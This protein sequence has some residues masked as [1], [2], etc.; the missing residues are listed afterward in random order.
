M[1]ETTLNSR[2]RSHGEFTS[3]NDVTIT[4]NSSLSENEEALVQF[5]RDLKAIMNDASHNYFA[6]EHCRELYERFKSMHLL[7]LPSWPI[8]F[9]EH[10]AMSLIGALESN[11]VF[12]KLIL[13]DSTIG[14]EEAIA[15]A[16]VLESNTTL[17]MLNLD[18]NWIGNEG[19]TALAR[20]LE[21]NMT[22]KE[23]NLARNEI[24]KE[25][26][27]ALATALES[28]T[29]LE[30]LHLYSNSIGNEGAT[31]LARV[32]ESNNT[33]LEKLYLSELKK[34]LIDELTN[35]GVCFM[36]REKGGV[37]FYL[38]TLQE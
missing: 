2:K 8:P 17:E 4:T 7:K 15:L 5:R 1:E 26:A 10:V 16:R 37:R 18:G 22:L 3:P 38:L 27:M 9:P 32:L 35:K 33:T 36:K 20:S 13:S 12:K 24:R 14:D 23:L 34:A 21:S 31:A 11:T 28:N 6:R 25:G 30:T 19:A 29:T